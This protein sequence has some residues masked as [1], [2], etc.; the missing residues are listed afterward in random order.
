M[1]GGVRAGS[2]TFG[3]DNKHCYRHHWDRCLIAL[4]RILLVIDVNMQ[5]LQKDSGTRREG[6]ELAQ[7]HS[8]SYEAQVLGNSLCK[9][10]WVHVLGQLKSSFDFYCLLKE[11]L[12]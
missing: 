6:G 12:F 10:P 9:C 3:N 1:E 11:R 4:A 8:D 2:G 7:W 5:S